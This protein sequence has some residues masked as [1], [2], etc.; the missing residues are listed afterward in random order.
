M[1]L[2][3]LAA[4]YER[5]NTEARGPGFAVELDVRGRFF[6][7]RIGTGRTVLDVGC[8]DGTVAQAYLEGNRV[9]GVDV[10][11][12]ALERAAARGLETTWAD[13]TE[14]LPFD[15]G[16]FDA[17][18]AGE[19]LE[20]LPAPDRLVA[21]VARVLRPGGTFVGSVPNAYRL[22]N[23]LRVLAGRTFDTD[24]THLR[25]FSPDSLRSLLAH[26][27]DDIEVHFFA[28]RL[29]RLSPRA[30]GNVMVFAARRLA[31]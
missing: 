25:Q 23:R 12:Q 30:F 20:H 9:S 28:G 6:V 7:E 21:E 18:V 24:P 2:D 3:Q 19:L 15:D 11:R 31:P 1:S 10:D 8:R 27:F 26:R 13:V 16:S 5:H 22:K 29:V 17:A 4:R 14:P